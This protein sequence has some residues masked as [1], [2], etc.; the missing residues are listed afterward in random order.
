MVVLCQQRLVFH[1]MHVLACVYLSR[2]YAS[3]MAATSGSQALDLWQ[4]LDTFHH[5][6][7]HSRQM[8]NHSALT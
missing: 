1:L 5:M 8:V 6:T 3:D 4:Q 2:Y 7:N